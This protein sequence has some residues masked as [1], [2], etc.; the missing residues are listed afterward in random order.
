MRILRVILLLVIGALPAFGK[1]L[2]ECRVLPPSTGYWIFDATNTSTIQLSL[3]GRYDDH[4]TD[5]TCLGAG[6]TVTWA[7]ENSNV[8]TVNSSGLATGVGITAWSSST[9][10]N[11]GQTASSGGFSW[12]AVAITTNEVP[13]SGGSWSKGLGTNIIAYNGSIFGH[14][15]VTVVPYAM[16]C[17]NIRPETTASNIVLGATILLS[18]QDCSPASGAGNPPVDGPAIGN[19]PA[20]TS[21]NTSIATIDNVGLVTAVGVGSA[22]ITATLPGIT[23]TRTVTVTNPTFSGNTWFV[24]SDGGTIKDT[25][26]PG[27]QCDATLDVAFAGSSG[28]H[29]AVNEIMYCY[30]DETSSS[31]YTGVVQGGDLCSV[32]L[33]TAGTF[34]H[35]AQKGPGTAWVTAALSPGAIAPPSGP[36]TFTTT[37]GTFAPGTSGT[38]ASCTNATVGNPVRITGAGVGGFDYNGTVVS[39]TSTTLTV[40]PATTVSVTTGTAVAVQHPTR[41]I[42]TGTSTCEIADPLH[43]GTCIPTISYGA[44]VF[45]LYDVQNF[46]VQGIDFWSGADCNHLQSNNLD[47]A[48][49]SGS[50]VRMAF[51]ADQLTANFTMERVRVHGYFTSLSSTTGPGT[52]WTNVASLYHA[53]D[54]I[55]FDNPFGFNG[56]RTY[57]FSLINS[58]IGFGGFTE[59]L[60]KPLAGGSVA[61]DGAGHLNVTF[62][63]GSL[64][65]Y[66]STT[67]LVLTGMTPSDLN[68]TYPVT[69]V[70]FNQHTATLI[71][72]SFRPCNDGFNTVGCADFATS[73]APTFG[74]G[75]FVNITGVPTLTFLNAGYEVLSINTSPVGFTIAGSIFT[76]PGWQISGTIASGGTASTAL[77]LVATAAGSS[78]TA[79]GLG[80]A[81]HVISAHRGMDQ[82]DTGNSNGDCVGTGN[83]TIGSWITMGSRFIRCTQ[84]GWD[85]LHS[86]MTASIAIGNYSEGVEGQAIKLGDSDTAMVKNNFIVANSGVNMSPD[87]NFPPEYNQYLTTFFRAGD[88]ML[89]HNEAFDSM[90]MSNNTILNAQNVTWDD[91]FDSVLRP[92]PFTQ[93]V[94]QNNLVI[95][96]SD[97]NNPTWNSS[98]PTIYFPGASLYTTVT[99]TYTNN[100]AFNGRN[101]PSGGTGNNWTLSSCPNIACVGNI[102]TFAGETAAQQANWNMNLIAG[103]PVGGGA[104]NSFTPA[105]DFN[106]TTT[107]VPSVVGAVNLVG[108]VTPSGQFFGA[109]S[110][111]GKQTIFP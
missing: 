82:A 8:L 63:S 35:L 48:C 81:G 53:L 59:E 22:T 72:G 6:G 7:T 97:S 109:G 83:N 85:M 49:P 9:T 25:N 99:W 62:P 106:G 55:N 10:Y 15:G 4:S 33:P 45:E 74:V 104:N 12:V 57:G 20:W 80:N 79:T 94:F 5:T 27:G 75:D 68:G 108:V 88:G 76:R 98:L 36:Y 111:I 3:A 65:N 87:P 31:V 100:M 51:L 46:D 70:N 102:S 110:F 32:R 13:G 71:G 101:P 90:V 37:S 44:V 105:T 50:G 21:S 17:L 69:S 2:V 42:G 28:G 84:D 11:P 43:L 19:Y 60:P 67:N 1:T 78:E 107:T 47:F 29:C 77:S 39:C 41:L 73:S 96:Y 56:N 89:T 16:T 54:G 18:A 34:Y 93:Y 92:L 30:T 61:R 26:V 64:V 38:V 86:A 40:S 52:V 91:Q 23:Q 14:S 103:I 24:R 58:Y 95:S 66:I